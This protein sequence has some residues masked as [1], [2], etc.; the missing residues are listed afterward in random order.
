MANFSLFPVSSL[1]FL[2]G[3]TYLMVPCLMVFLLVFFGS[4]CDRYL[5]GAVQMFCEWHFCGYFCAS[6]LFSFSVQLCLDCSL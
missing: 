4:L 5:L 6:F 3:E 1:C 2:I